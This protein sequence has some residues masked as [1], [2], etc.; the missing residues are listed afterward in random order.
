ML[1]LV[2]YAELDDSTDRFEVWWFTGFNEI[3]HRRVDVTPVSQHV[4]EAGPGEEAAL[5]AS[6][7]FSDSV[8]IGIKEEAELRVKGFVGL[9]VRAQQKSFEELKIHTYMMDGSVPTSAINT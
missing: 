6:L 4:L 7:T 3:S 9:C 8:V 2:V 1:L 5:M